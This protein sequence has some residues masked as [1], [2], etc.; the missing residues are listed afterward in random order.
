M[1][2]E[3]FVSIWLY[4]ICSNVVLEPGAANW[5]A[6]KAASYVNYITLLFH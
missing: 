1:A 3:R 2:F 5:L 6:K 4:L